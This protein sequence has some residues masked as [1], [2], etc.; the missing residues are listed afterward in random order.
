VERLRF[1]IDMEGIREE[2]KHETTIMA[3]Q[4]MDVPKE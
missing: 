3:K 1:E 4:S 2:T